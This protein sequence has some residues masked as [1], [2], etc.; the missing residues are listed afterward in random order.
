M[1]SVSFTRMEDGTQAEYQLLEGLWNDHHQGRLADNVL[2][3]L[4]TNDP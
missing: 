2:A 1:E 3:M 4:N